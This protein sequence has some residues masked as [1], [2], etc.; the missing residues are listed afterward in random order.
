MTNL[1]QAFNSRF[2]QKGTTMIEVMVT[3]F[4]VAVGLLG[5]AGLQS[6]GLR[7]ASNSHADA[8]AQILSQDLAEMILAYDTFA[9]GDYAMDAVPASKGKECLTTNCTATEL[10]QYNVWTWAQNMQPALPSFDLDIGF[11]APSSSY[12]IVLTW[13]AN[14]EGAS[15][16]APSCAPDDNFKAGCFAMLLTLTN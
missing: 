16:T 3:I 7:Q 15:F 12:D 13:D 6:V 1:N 9:N 11:D 14:R 10:A 4:I 2:Y 5:V 8:Q